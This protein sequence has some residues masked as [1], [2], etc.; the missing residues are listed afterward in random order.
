MEKLDIKLTP[1]MREFLRKQITLTTFEIEQI[2]KRRRRKLFA[3]MQA[4]E[5][6]IRQIEEEIEELRKSA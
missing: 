5:N 4:I 1:A 2:L 6:E 3:K